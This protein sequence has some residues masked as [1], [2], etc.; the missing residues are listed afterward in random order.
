MNRISPLKTDRG[1]R[2]LQGAVNINRTSRETLILHNLC[3]PTH[4]HPQSSDVPERRLNDRSFQ[5]RLAFPELLSK[6]DLATLSLVMP[7]DV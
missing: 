6:G 3:L 5:I 2:D 4:I 7:Y 1:E